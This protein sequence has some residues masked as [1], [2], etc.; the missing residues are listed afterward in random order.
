MPFFPGA[1]PFFRAPCPFFSAPCFQNLPFLTQMLSR[2]MRRYWVVSDTIM[3]WC[4]VLPK[5]RVPRTHPNYPCTQLLNLQS[6]TLILIEGSHLTRGGVNAS[7]ITPGRTLPWPTFKPTISV[8]TTVYISILYLWSK[9]LL[10]NTQDIYWDTYEKF[11]FKVPD[12]IN[13]VFFYIYD[14]MFR[15]LSHQSFYSKKHY[16]NLKARFVRYSNK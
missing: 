7:P 14:L 1:M 6:V 16:L 8:Y 13:E 12:M 5:W 4:M 11:I 2:R 3:F 10:I 9:R 15:H